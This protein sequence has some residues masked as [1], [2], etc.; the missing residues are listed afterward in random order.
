MNK[1]LT[2]PTLLL[3]MT[4]AVTLLAMP[5]ALVLSGRP[6]PGEIALVIAPP[7]ASAG[8]AAGVVAAAGGREIGPVRAPFAVLAVLDA[9]EAA[10]R[11]GAWIVLDGRIMALVCGVSLLND[12]R[13]LD[14]A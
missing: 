14:L 13:G 11:L 3:V 7:W 1:R 2:P 10:M 12:E 6:Q 5:V 4:I 8:G 9:P